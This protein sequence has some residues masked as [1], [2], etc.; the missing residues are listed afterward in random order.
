ME[1]RVIIASIVAVFFGVYIAFE[2]VRNFCIA[3]PEFCTYGWTLFVALII[4]AA[5]FLKYRLFS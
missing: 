1:P 3:T 4:G 5:T 2:I